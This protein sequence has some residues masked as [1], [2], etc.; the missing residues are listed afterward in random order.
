MFFAENFKS[1]L[2]ENDSVTQTNQMNFPSSV[3]EEGMLEVHLISCVMIEKNTPVKC[4]IKLP[5]QD[6]QTFPAEIAAN[7]NPRWGKKLNQMM[8]LQGGEVIFI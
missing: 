4:E 1:K 2:I 5:N 7:G 8:K 6:S 3:A